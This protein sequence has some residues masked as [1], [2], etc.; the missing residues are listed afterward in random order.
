MFSYLPIVS[1]SLSTRVLV[2]NSTDY[3]NE[4]VSKKVGVETGQSFKWLQG[5]TNFLKRF[6]IN[7]IQSPPPPPP[8]I[9]GQ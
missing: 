2:D 5:F 6:G 1:I 9:S 3:R 4:S 8:P 7:L